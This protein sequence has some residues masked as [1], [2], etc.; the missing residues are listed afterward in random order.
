MNEY[1]VNHE[2]IL[3][4]LLP[5]DPRGDPVVEMMARIVAQQAPEELPMRARIPGT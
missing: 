4:I 2:D 5:S 3:A 1:E